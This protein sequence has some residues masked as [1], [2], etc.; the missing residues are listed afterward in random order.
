MARAYHK[1]GGAD[2][3]GLQTL[4]SE[5]ELTAYWPGNMASCALR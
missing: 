3:S 2:R 4:A 1:L 5:D